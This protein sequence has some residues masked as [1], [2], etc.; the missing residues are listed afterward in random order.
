EQACSFATAR[1]AG[2]ARAALKSFASA[3][4]T[5]LPEAR[6]EGALRRRGTPGRGMRHPAGAILRF[7]QVRAA[8]LVTTEELP[9]FG[10]LVVEPVLLGEVLGAGGEAEG[11]AVGA[12][13]ARFSLELGQAGAGAEIAAHLGAG[14]RRGHGAAPVD[15][16]VHDQVPE[17][18]EQHGAEEIVIRRRLG[19]GPVV[20]IHVVDRQS[21]V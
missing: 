12:D 9:R 14:R 10:A 20:L 13:T 7:E 3:A 15:H 21:V 17:L 6:A 2:L 19:E 18:V 11:H 8:R 1:M 16:V 5:A 4:L